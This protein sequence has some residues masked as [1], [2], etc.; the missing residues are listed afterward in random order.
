MN[1]KKLLAIVIN[2][3][4]N[5]RY[6]DFV[7]LIEAFGFELYRTK[8]SHNIYKHPKV[9]E[10]L[11]TQNLKGKAKTYQIEQ[12]LDYVEDYGLEMEEYHD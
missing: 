7:S 3:P 11:N 12:F 1:K 2:N 5:V 9:V 4:K 8:G 6:V 10:I